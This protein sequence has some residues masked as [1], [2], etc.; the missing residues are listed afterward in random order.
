MNPCDLPPR[1]YSYDE[2]AAYPDEAR[3]E[4]HN[5]TPVTL[6]A[7]GFGRSL[8]YA[9]LVGYLLNWLGELDPGGKRVQNF[10]NV[11]WQLDHWNSLVLDLCFFRRER[12]ASETIRRADDQCLVARPDLAIHISDSPLSAALAPWRKAVCQRQK[13]PYFWEIDIA[14]RVFWAVR[15]ENGKYGG[16]AVL[17]DED[18]LTPF[19]FPGLEFALL[20]VFAEAES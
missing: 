5:G 6:F 3:R 20:G 12:F 19:P 15:L 2:I 18:A 14:E 4:L 11:D 9:E 13:V 7:P 8:A 1:R 17:T 10:I 16:D